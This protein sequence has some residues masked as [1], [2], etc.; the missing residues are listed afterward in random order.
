ML[1]L[2]RYRPDWLNRPC[3]ESSLNL[4]ATVF[5]NLLALYPFVLFKFSDSY[6]VFIQWLLIQLSVRFAV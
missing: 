1:W 3:G 4:A 6:A 2:L 5:V